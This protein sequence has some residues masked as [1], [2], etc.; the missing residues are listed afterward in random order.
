MR[1]QV[2]WCIKRRINNIESDVQNIKGVLFVGI[3]AGNSTSLGKAGPWCTK[4]HRNNVESDLQNSKGVLFV[5]IYDENSKL[6]GKAGPWCI[7]RR[8]NNVESDLQ[9]DIKNGEGVLF[10]EIYVGIYAGNSTSLGK[11]G[12]VI[13]YG[14]VWLPD[15]PLSSSRTSQSCDH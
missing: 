4:R 8:R 7:K 5:E 1:A 12:R 10:V 6:L 14:L 3:Y 15:Y 9:N 11:T 2:P 13:R